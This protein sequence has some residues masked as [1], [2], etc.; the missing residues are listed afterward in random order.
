M[1]VRGKSKN[2]ARRKVICLQKFLEKYFYGTRVF[3]IICSRTE[4]IV[5]IS[6]IVLTFCTPTL[7]YS[8]N[9]S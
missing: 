8:E 2:K 5:Q 7:V 3:N 1:F 9:F 6:R 4:P